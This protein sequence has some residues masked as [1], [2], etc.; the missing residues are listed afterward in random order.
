MPHRALL[1]LLW[2]LAWCLSAQELGFQAGA[3]HH[4]FSTIR[5]EGYR[6]AALT[7]F[8]PQALGSWWGGD[9]G[10][11]LR[12][13]RHWG[14]DI[15]ILQDQATPAEWQGFQARGERPHLDLDHWMVAALPVWRRPLG[16]WAELEAGFGLAETNREVIT[17]G[18]KWSFYMLLGL[19]HRVG[20]WRDGPLRVGLRMEHFSNGG[21]LG[22]TPAR[23]IG[24]E[25]LQGTV[26]WHF[27]RRTSTP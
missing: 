20:T 21:T 2:T 4:G 19:N 25:S 11:E 16:K 5:Y 15:P 23:V 12:T 17:G 26:S 3:S 24:L 14:R 1:F 6:T 22:V 13:S 8:F 7:V 9:L 18:T 10:L 27:G